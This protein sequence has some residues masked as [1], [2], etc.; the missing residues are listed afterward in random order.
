MM[1][2]D[3]LGQW[4]ET[5][6]E[7]IQIRESRFLD[8]K[9]LTAVMQAWRTAFVRQPGRHGQP[10]NSAMAFNPYMTRRNAAWRQYQAISGETDWIA[11]LDDGRADAAARINSHGVPPIEAVEGVW[12]EA[13][14]R[15]DL[16]VFDVGATWSL[17][18]PHEDV[19]PVF[20]QQLPRG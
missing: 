15:Y 14:S 4:L 11:V 1:P 5:W 16:Y 7:I 18:L 17:T 2:C 8:R 10:W 13:R 19:G 9:E 20:F 3:V 6:G 12:N